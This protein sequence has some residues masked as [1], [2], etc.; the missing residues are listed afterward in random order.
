MVELGYGD[1]EDLLNCEENGCLAAADPSLVSIRAKDRGRDQLGTIGAGN[2]FVEIEVVEEIFDEKAAE[3]FG[4]FLNQVVILIHTGSRGF[5]HQVATDYIREMIRAMPKRGIFLRD[6]ELAC[7]PFDSKEGRDYFRA[8]AAAAN[9]AWA[10]RQLVSWEVRRAWKGVL[11]DQ[12]G[13]LDLLYDVAHNIAKVETYAVSGKNKELVIHRKGATR[14]F[15]DQP[16][17][18]PGSMG[19]RFAAEVLVPEPVRRLL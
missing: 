13:D 8:M 16:V 12:A 19:T 9:F 17:L 11:G 2:H 10:N 18:V 7:A 15:P 5:G 1:P 4:L 14:S 3:V 6:R